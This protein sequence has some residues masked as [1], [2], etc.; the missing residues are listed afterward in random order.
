MNKIKLPFSKH[1]LL[2]ISILF[3]NCRKNEKIETDSFISTPT[4]NISINDTIS[5]HKDT[6]YKY[7]YRTGSSGDYGYNYDV[8]GYDKSNEKITGNVT[9]NGKYGT[10][11]FS[12]IEG[13]KITIT[14]E[15]V[16]YGVLKAIDDE[17]N[18][19]DLTVD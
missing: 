12:N 4:K 19:Y 16:G 11:Y 10:G 9:M 5:Y 13:E 6:T 2:L 8:T 7:E 1:F 17:G 14:V 18:E 3:F 15:W